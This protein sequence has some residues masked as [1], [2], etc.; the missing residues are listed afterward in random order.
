[1][2]DSFF[3]ITAQIAEPDS[4]AVEIG[5]TKPVGRTISRRN[6][7]WPTWEFK[8]LIKENRFKPKPKPKPKPKQ[9]SKPG[10]FL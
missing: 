5:R 9:K 6:Y 10:P 7:S 8:A 2:L 3:V 1:L 4:G